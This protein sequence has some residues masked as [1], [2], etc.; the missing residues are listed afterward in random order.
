MSFTVI[1]TLFAV[2]LLVAML[3]LLEFGRHIG[4]R[5]AQTTKGV[6]KGAAVVE[7]A[8][9]GLV[10]LIL[11]FA[12]SNALSSFQQERQMIGQ[13]AGAIGTAWDRLDL[14]HDQDRKPLQKLFL[15]YL[16]SRLDAFRKQQ[17]D[18][19]PQEFHRT[20]E[21]QGQIWKQAVAGCRKDG[22]PHVF[23]LLLPAINQMF[24][25]SRTRNVMA[26]IHPPRVV[27]EMLFFLLLLCALLAGYTM[28]VNDSRS[29]IHKM[30]FTLSISL[31]AFIITDLE[32]PHLGLFRIG[33]SD[34]RNLLELREKLSRDYLAG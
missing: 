28:S 13:E 2:S 14:L 29:W 8:V 21:L 23:N 30:A 11:G 3:C 9:F 10:G 26:N 12:F 31:T 16:D 34:Y 33:I 1:N 22:E 7:S 25:I 15:Q 19:T 24:D 20:V 4:I 27:A 5:Q 32:F 18:F 6:P 17:D